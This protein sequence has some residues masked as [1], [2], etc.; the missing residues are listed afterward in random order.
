M[1]VL[2]AWGVALLNAVHYTLFKLRL[3]PL[4]RFRRYPSHWEPFLGS[5]L[6]WNTRMTVLHPERFP[7]DSPVVLAAL[8]SKLDDPL[9]CWGAVH[10]AT[11]GAVHI[12]F[13][14]RDDFFRGWPWDYLPFSM[15]ELTEA[16]GCIQISRDSISLAQL[17]PL[18]NVLAHGD[19]FVMFPGRTRTR[20]GR[21]IDYIDG[22]DEPGGVSFFL[23]HG[24]RRA[25]RPVAAVPLAR[26]YDPVTR[27]TYVCFGKPRYLP[28]RAG[29]DAQRDFDFD[30]AVAMS[31]QLVV[32]PLHVLCV[33]VYLRCLH[34]RTEAR[35]VAEWTRDADAVMKRIAGRV[36]TPPRPAGEDPYLRYLRWLVRHGMLRLSGDEVAVCTDAVLA[37]PA[38]DTRFRKKNPVR[39]YTNQVLHFRCVVEAAEEVT[40]A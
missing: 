36:D 32:T 9:F 33:L 25:G 16:A 12:Y 26:T 1:R 4:P 30:L 40:L 3:L 27:H 11:R 17:K 14:M 34:G 23:L 2:F 6:R 18:I 7:A 38:I 31:N 15:N 21:A 39:F 37:L 10:R 29:R 8:H 5:F 35:Q 20:T 28:E 22:I 24:A 19:S 13:M